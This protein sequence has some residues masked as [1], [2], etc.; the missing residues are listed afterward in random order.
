VLILDFTLFSVQYLFVSQDGDG[1]KLTMKFGIGEILEI[2]SWVKK[3]QYDS[4]GK[5]SFSLTV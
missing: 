1:P 2:N 4:V 5:V 3:R